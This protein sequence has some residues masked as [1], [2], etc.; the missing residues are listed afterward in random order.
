VKVDKRA[1]KE[2]DEDEESASFPTSAIPDTLNARFA[3][4]A[5]LLPNNSKESHV[6]DDGPVLLTLLLSNQNDNNNAARQGSADGTYVL[7][8]LPP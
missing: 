6:D 4:H 3:V 1:A 8:L 7:L 2:T 5:V